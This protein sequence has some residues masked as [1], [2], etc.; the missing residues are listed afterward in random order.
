MSN[1]LD[2]LKGKNEDRIPVWFMRQA[3]RYLT[4]YME[5]KESSSFREMS[6]TPEIMK[7]I[8]LQPLKRYDLDAAIMFSDILTCLE[9]MGAPF[10]FTDSGPKLESH[11]TEIVKNL[12]PLKPEEDLSYVGK[13]IQLIKQEETSRPLIGFVGAPFTLLSYLVEGGTSREFFNTKRFLMSESSAAVS[14]L[15]HIST[16]LVSYTKFQ[17]ESGVNAIQIFDSWGGVLSRKEYEALVFPSLEKLVNQTAQHGVPVTLYAQP[18]SHLLSLFAR[19]D[20]SAISVDWRQDIS[21]YFKIVDSVRAGIALQGNLDPIVPTLN[22]DLAKPHV[23]S[24]LK[25]IKQGGYQSRFI[26]NVG[27]GLTPK[28]NMETVASIITHVHQS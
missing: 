23:D 26:F 13:G 14:A 9:Y 27:H 7:E 19:L 22:W 17:V 28:T 16:Q 6:H 10:K 15:D 21:D 12:T 5:I 24:I 11:G 3:G 4:E 2:A 25:S 8:T 18:S 1:Y 20:V